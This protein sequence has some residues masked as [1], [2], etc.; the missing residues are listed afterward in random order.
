MRVTSLSKS[1]VESY[2]DCPF[3]YYLQYMC[4]ISSPAGKAAALGVCFHKILELQALCHQRG[5]KCFVTNDL[6][7]ITRICFNRCIKENPGFTFTEEDYESCLTWVDRIARS[8]RGPDKHRKILGVEQKFR[9]EFDKPGLGYKY[10]GKD[11]RLAVNG[12]ID[13]VVEID[14]DTIE[15]INYKTGKSAKDWN[16]G[17][18]KTLD[19][20]QKDIQLRLYNLVAKQMYP[21]YKYRLLTLVYIQARKVYSVSM[22]LDDEIKTVDVMRRHFQTISQ[23]NTP[24]RIKE[25]GLRSKERYKCYKSCYYGMQTVEDGGRSI[26]DTA[27]E[28]AQAHGYQEAVP[29]VQMTCSAKTTGDQRKPKSF[30][31]EKTITGVIT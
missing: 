11:G 2:T 28:L 24:M 30:V 6:P 19:D 7:K 5:K 31:D 10:D 16:T 12:V 17:R 1:G 9:Y 4:R 22:D 13:L 18:I 29:F 25:N 20:F 14:E 3:K 15:I 26:C 8:N 27:Y 23:D 21:Q